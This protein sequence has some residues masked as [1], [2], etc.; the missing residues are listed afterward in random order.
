M[1]R[2]RVY[3]H[4]LRCPHCGSNGTPKDSHSQGK[5]TYRCGNR[6]YYSQ[7]VKNQALDMYGEGSCISAIGRSLNP[8][9]SS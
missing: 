9:Q 1:A 5:Q 8:R 2:A 7:A 4:G 3:R 6:H